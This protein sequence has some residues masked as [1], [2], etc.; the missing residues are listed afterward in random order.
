MNCPSCSSENTTV[1]E[2][3]ETDDDTLFECDDCLDQFLGEEA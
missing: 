3:G 1:I 2:V